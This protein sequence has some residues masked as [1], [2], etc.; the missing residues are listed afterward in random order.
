[1]TRLS[2]NGDLYRYI[3]RLEEDLR[4]KGAERL[5]DD[6]QFAAGQNAGL[7]TEFL[8]EC[9]IAL[10]KV[11]K[12]SGDMLKDDDRSELTSAIKQVEFVLKR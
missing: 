10:R 11:E 2:N 6:L 4:N 7:S 3:L 5:A 8:G 1:M 9:L 12:F